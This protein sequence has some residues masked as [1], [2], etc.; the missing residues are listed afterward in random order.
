MLK[1]TPD[2]SGVFGEAMKEWYLLNESTPR[3]GVENMAA[4]QHFLEQVEAG[5]LDAPLLRLYRWRNPTLSLGYHQRWAD[6][7]SQAA[8]A[9]HGIDLVRR[10][11]G[12]RGVLHEP[13]EITYS[14][15]APTREPFKARVSHNY[16]L[17]G[18]AL[19]RFTQLEGARGLMSEADDDVASVRAQ[20]GLPCFAS[21]SQSE[22]EAKGQKLIGSAQKL[23]RDAFLQHGSIPMIHRHKVL[24]QITATTSDVSHKMTGI[25][26]FYAHSGQPVPGHTELCAR[27]ISAFCEAF[28]ISFKP[29]PTTLP[30]NDRIAALVKE[31]FSQDSW[32]F[33]K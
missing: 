19:E 12:G 20:R 9:E 3:L 33:R 8:L 14:L 32:T 18:I 6:T 22:I 26:E 27:L 5:A 16:R 1:V 28:D 17:I 30:D 24:A 11:T 4:D 29:L 7:V 23:G 25:N 10:W 31:R 2:R 21:L 15:I 13:D